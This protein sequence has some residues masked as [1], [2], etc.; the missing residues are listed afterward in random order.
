MKIPKGNSCYVG[1]AGGIYSWERDCVESS[2][3]LNYQ[4]TTVKQPRR[5]GARLHTLALRGPPWLP[6][7]HVYKLANESG[8]K[9]R[10]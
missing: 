10:Y 4:K 2:V 5:V 3:S 1:F 6:K 8:A 7:A 9:F